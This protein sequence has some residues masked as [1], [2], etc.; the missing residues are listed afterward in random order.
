M[1]L[2]VPRGPNAGLHLFDAKFRL[3]RQDHERFLSEDLHKM[4]AY[5]DA[6]PAAR[7]AW[8]LYPGA[9]VGAYFD[10][11]GRDLRSQGPVAGVGALPLAPGQANPALDQLLAAM[12]AP[13]AAEAKRSDLQAPA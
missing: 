2:F 13:Q 12:L 8:V 11:G 1:A 9:D 4:H 5:R 3:D 7:S 6:I 10:D